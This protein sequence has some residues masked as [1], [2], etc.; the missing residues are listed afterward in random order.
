[1]DPHFR[2]SAVILGSRSSRLVW[3]DVDPKTPVDFRWHRDAD[4][5]FDFR[6][7][8]SSSH[9][10][11]KVERLESGDIQLQSVGEEYPPEDIQEML[12]RRLEQ[13]NLRTLLEM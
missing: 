3:G 7:V 6:R 5:N 13:V 8:D 4:G 10:K 11:F 9:V 12:R 2:D 1:M